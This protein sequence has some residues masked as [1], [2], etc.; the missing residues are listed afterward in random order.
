[1]LFGGPGEE[2]VRHMGPDVCQLSQMVSFAGF[3]QHLDSGPRHFAV[4][5]LSSSR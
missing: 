4:H 5:E 2:E 1:M 3:A